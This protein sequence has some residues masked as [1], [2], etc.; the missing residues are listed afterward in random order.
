MPQGKLKALGPMMAR[1]GEEAVVAVGDIR[2]GLYL[3]V[4]VGDGWMSPNL[5]R[6]EGDAAR[7][8]DPSEELMDLI[9]NAW[10]SEDLGRRWCVMEY[11]V[12]G[13]EFDARFKFPDE[14][15]VEDTETDRREIALRQRFG[16]KPI[17]YPSISEGF[18]ELG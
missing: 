4:E 3:Y 18:Q 17:I 9:W 6:D 16:N 7:W 2:D 1:I 8:F 15:D 10:K 11:E 14:I 13:N 12:H 5:Y